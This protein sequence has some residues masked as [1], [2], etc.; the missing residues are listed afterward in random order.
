MQVG[1]PGAGKT[2]WRTGRFPDRAVICLDDLRVRLTDDMGDQ[3]ANA[4]A[5][6]IMHKFVVERMQRGLPTVIDATNTRHEYR[7]PL[8]LAA[9]AFGM[10]VIAVVFHVPHAVCV[11][12]V[13]ERGH[14]PIPDASIRRHGRQLRAELAKLLADAAIAVELNRAHRLLR[15]RIDPELEQAG[16][17]PQLMALLK[18]CREY[19]PR[20]GEIRPD[21]HQQGRRDYGRRTGSRR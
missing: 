5:V 7:K 11:A 16:I 15:L 8:I 17:S 2:T 19:R 21:A 13:E 1:A 12:R 3:S 10:P 14:N 20:E 18:L 6:A 9:R 4:A